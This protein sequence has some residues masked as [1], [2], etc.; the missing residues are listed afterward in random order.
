MK[1]RPIILFIGLGLILAVFGLAQGLM[2]RHPSAPLF[3]LIGVVGLVLA[4]Y[5]T[6]R[7]FRGN[8]PTE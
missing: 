3:L 8:P 4:I 7:A 1:F 2:V 5:G 6:I